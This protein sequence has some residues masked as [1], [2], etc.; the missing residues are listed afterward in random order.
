MC[1]C[2]NHLA[3]PIPEGERLVPGHRLVGRARQIDHALDG[4][5]I[6]SRAIEEPLRIRTARRAEWAGWTFKE[7]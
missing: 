5:R 7:R 3:P 6:L 4:I 2:S 1:G